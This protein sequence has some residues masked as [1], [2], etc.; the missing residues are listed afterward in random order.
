MAEQ[1]RTQYDFSGGEI[2]T[3]MLMRGDAEVYAKSLLE[4]ENFQPTLQG[5]A[6]RSPG[7]RF[8]YDT[9]QTT[10]RIIP[11]QTP[12]N[13]SGFV[14]LAEGSI[15][16]KSKYGLA[17]RPNI[18]LNRANA[19]S[20]LAPIAIR[21]Q[22]MP[23]GDFI[24]SADPWVLDPLEYVGGAEDTLGL[25]WSGLL[26]GE[27]LGTA[28]IWKTTDIDTC[29]VTGE[30]VVD[31]PTTNIT[32]D[33][34]LEYLNNFSSI[35]ADY[36]ATI[37]IGKTPGS[38]EVMNYVF[39]G[40]VG[41]IKDLIQTHSLDNG[42]QWTGTLYVTVTWQAKA[43]A[44]NPHSAPQFRLQ[45]LN[46]WADG[47]LDVDDDVIGGETPPW[48]EDELGDVHFVQSPYGA[49]LDDPTFPAKQLVLVH[50]SYTPYML[51]FNTDANLVL[52][53]FYPNAGD[54]PAGYV[55][56]KIP[57]VNPPVWIEGDYP[58]TC[59][60]FMGRLILAGAQNMPTPGDPSVAATETVWGT[61]SGNWME[62]SEEDEVNPSDSI[63]ITTIYRSP[64][65][66]VYGQKTLLIGARE[67]EYSASADGIFNPG[68]ISVEMHS[69]HGGAHVQPAGFGKSV[70][71]ASDG[72]TRVREMSFH[73]E[74]QGW[75]ASDLTLLNPEL[76][77]AGIV[78]IIRMRNPH[79]MVV[80]LLATGQIAL[81]HAD[82]MLGVAGWSRLNVTS[83]TSVKDVCTIVDEDGVDIL[84]M[85]VERTVNGVRKLYV[86]AIPNWTDG[87]KWDYMTSSTL[88][89]PGVPTNVF[90]GLDHLE[91][92]NVQ[93]VGDRDY[94]GTFM[95]TDGTVTL[96]NQIGQ[97][98]VVASAL[99]GRAMPARMK[100]L[101]VP[102]KDAGSEKRYKSISCRVRLSTR[103]LINGE[104]PDDRTPSRIMDKSE[105]LVGIED[106]K[107]ANFGWDKY[108]V[109]TIEENTPLRCEV[110]GIYGKLSMNSV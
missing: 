33:F 80:V 108:Q 45:R 8:I 27:V 49:P 87:N 95:V 5:S 29:T 93:V 17:L 70:L 103:P 44:A 99:I 46:I 15:K 35:D 22:I 109:I 38:K 106:T 14:E 85:A 89:R 26:G 101:P 66:W 34:Y 64:I 9:E 10:V 56:L 78:R 67:M 40:G 90:T 91:G 3:R 12:A 48:L 39:D 98:I 107:V 68:D 81:F 6:E 77:K 76:T 105:E 100:T 1:D 11:Y 52:P 20:Q 86:E 2:S 32:V 92:V 97:P 57:F 69:T 73:N 47:E 55:L 60:S 74:D 43:T 59:T 36:A 31:Y 25:R 50:P 58:N 7:T 24:S 71:F 28:R 30:C 84:V 51:F 54:I 65:Q 79:Q 72:G 13:V 37:H 18:S 63:E 104:R 19:P 102:A 42:N 75:V 23:N 62:F 21:K 94:L 96:L 53:P 110:L 16:I 83:G 61:Q 41:T 82:P 88:Y 4:M